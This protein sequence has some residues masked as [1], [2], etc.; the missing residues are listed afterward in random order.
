MEFFNRL[1]ELREGTG[2]NQ[3][4]FAASMNMEQSKYNKW[5]NGKNAPDYEGLCLI[6]D[7]FGVTVDY[8]LGRSPYKNSEEIKR[9]DDTLSSIF[10]AGHTQKY[11][12]SCLESLR[13]VFQL[14]S[15][16]EKNSVE[17]WTHYILMGLSKLSKQTIGQ[18]EVLGMVVGPD[19]D[20]IGCFVDF[21]NEIIQSRDDTVIM[22]QAFYATL[23]DTLTLRYMA[24]STLEDQTILLDASKQMKNYLD[25]RLRNPPEFIAKYKKNREENAEA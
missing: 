16:I 2:M 13:D 6:A 25:P 5:E 8:L 22:L 24:I 19:E 18:V 12:K 20:A 4:E 11:A 14:S 9:I 7:R 21:C 23:L 1:K 3:K 15:K 17:I 10:F